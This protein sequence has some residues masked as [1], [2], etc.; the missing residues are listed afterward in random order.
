M[1]T[2]N[3]KSQ[4]AAMQLRERILVAFAWHSQASPRLTPTRIRAWL[5]KHYNIKPPALISI[6][7]H[8]TWL[9]EHGFIQ[10]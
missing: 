1:A 2:R 6:K 5:A 4:A 10:R 9:I 7:R 8:T 3:T